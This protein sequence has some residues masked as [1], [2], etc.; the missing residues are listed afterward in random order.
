MA[1]SIG[2]TKIIGVM[3]A[4]NSLEKKIVQRGK[5]IYSRLPDTSPSIFDPSWWSG[6]LLEWAMKDPDFKVRMFRFI[7]VLPVLQE[8]RQV[9]R[10][11]REYF[12]DLGE[13]LPEAFR[14][15]M[16]AASG[17]LTSRLVAPMVRK[18]LELMAHRFIAGKNPAEGLRTLTKLRGKR[19]AFTL[20]LLGEATLSEEEAEIYRQRYV[21]VIHFLADKVD[22]W[23][24]DPL[25][26]EDH[27]GPIP[28]LNV[29]VKVSALTSRL[30][31]LCRE[32]G[33]DAITARIVSILQ[34]AREKGALV[35]LDLE[36]YD[37]KT[38]TLSL[39]GKL[40][41]EEQFRDG[42]DLGIV[43]QA[44]LRDSPED[45]SRLIRWARERKRRITVRLVKGAYWDYDTVI[46][47]QKGWSIPVFLH[48]EETDANY[49]ALSRVLLK[50][51]DAVSPAFAGHNIRSIAHALAVAEEL[52]IPSSAY[53]I[54]MLNGMAEPIRQA[55]VELGY[56][57]RVYA[58]IGEMLPGMAYLVRRLLENTSNESFL[59]KNFVEG[60]P[61]ED[62]IAPPV[63][64]GK[65]EGDTSSAGF[66]NEPTADFADPSVRETF[67]ASF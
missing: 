65:E 49:E 44:Y 5:E 51:I 6:H 59:R 33:V 2:R 53:E 23:K 39:F 3:H 16:Q 43:V 38:F 29:S 45:L 4:E 54:Q 28:R 24:P 66:R 19:I 14:W 58:P 27:S 32:A 46:R 60:V 61:F 55:L 56:R 11:L 13:S 62:L 15:G 10:F 50:N 67:E 34:A 37:L 57:V 20:D 18:N 47:R 48:K 22:A 31:P 7:D 8:S 52:G 64:P 30:D 21:E 40:L 9:T 12:T 17:P 35:N 1:G 25:L 42:P 41:K 36:Q 63:P 26:D